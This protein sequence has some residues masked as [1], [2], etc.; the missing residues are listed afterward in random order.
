MLPEVDQTGQ[1][2]EKVNSKDAGL[3]DQLSKVQE[4]HGDERVGKP[5]E[6]D[7]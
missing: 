3:G 4:G 2:E 5:V 7:G 6:G 1:R